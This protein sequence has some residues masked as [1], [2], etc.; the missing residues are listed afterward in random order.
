MDNDFLYSGVPLPGLAV[1]AQRKTTAQGQW[2][3]SAVPGNNDTE[4]TV[5]TSDMSYRHFLVATDT[6]VTNLTYS[7]FPITFYK[8]QIKT[9]L[10]FFT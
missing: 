10:H 5:H 7:D 6:T 3:M 2:R 1:P 9:V 4:Q 8:Q